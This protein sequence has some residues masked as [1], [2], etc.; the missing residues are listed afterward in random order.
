MKDFIKGLIKL[1]PVPL[2][3]NHRYD[4]QTKKII[5]SLGSNFNGIDVG[6]HKGEILDIF[7]A[8][9]PKGKHFGIEALPTMAADLEKKYKQ[10]ENCN[11]LNFAASNQ[12]GEIEFNYVVSN[13]AYSGMLKRDYDRP[14]EEDTKIKVLTAKLDDEIPRDLRI[15]LIKIDVEGAELQVLE[16]AIN[17]I[18]NHQPIVVFE[19]GLGAS[20][21][22]GTTPEKLFEFFERVN[23][24]ISNLGNYLN[25]AEPLSLEALKR[26]Y[27]QRENHYFIAHKPK[28]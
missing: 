25:Q 21:H 4:I 13:P 6:C 28:R 18:R 22:Y 14:H 12:A 10:V 3:K 5:R 23:M 26:Q 20:N 9:S 2:T 1:S 16:G 24:K 15:D 8:C 19:F 17:L 27:Q 7:L 11:I